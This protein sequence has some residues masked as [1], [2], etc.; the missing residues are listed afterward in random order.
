MG[1]C[2]R[3]CLFDWHGHFVEDVKARLGL[4][5]NC[6]FIP[7]KREANLAA[8]T[9]AKAACNHVMRSFW[10]HCTPSFLDGIIRQ[11]RRHMGAT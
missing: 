5:R 6:S 9:I 2:L 1:L 11:E 10:W 7:V 4:M 8:H 3:V